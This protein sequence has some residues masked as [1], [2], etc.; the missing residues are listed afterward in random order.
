MAFLMICLNGRF[1][2][3]VICSLMRAWKSF[4]T[5]FCKSARREKERKLRSRKCR[6][7]C[8]SKSLI[9]LINT[10]TPWDPTLT[11]YKSISSSRLK[12]NSMIWTPEW[13]R[14]FPT[15]NGISPKKSLKPISYKKRDYTPFTPTSRN[16][17]TSSKLQLWPHRP[18]RLLK[19]KVRTT[20]SVRRNSI[21]DLGSKRPISTS[22]KEKSKRNLQFTQIGV[23]WPMFIGKSNFSNKT[24]FLMFA[25]ISCKSGF[26][27]SPPWSQ[28]WTKRKKKRK[29]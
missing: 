12:M 24:P 9:M 20:F 26:S 15:C 7:S 19:I 23:S 6:K 4:R 27:A 17:K 14:N 16:S 2:M 29:W 11:C 21:S 5:S 28:R 10:E 3:L 18:T 1:R 22:A 25:T 13:N 8:K